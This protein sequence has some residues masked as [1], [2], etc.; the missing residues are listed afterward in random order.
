MEN[1]LDFAEVDNSLDFD[2]PML[3]AEAQEEA[4]VT[5]TLPE[6]PEE[7]VVEGPSEAE[8][9]KF[10]KIYDDLFF[11]GSYEETFP[12][13]KRY[14]C[15]LKSRT[16]DED[17][18]IARQL[19]GMQFQTMSAYQTMAAVLSLSY[20]LMDLNGTDYSGMDQKARYDKV[21]ALPS[22]VVEM[23]SR[24]MST[25]DVSIRNALGYGEENF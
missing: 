24:H 15:K 1:K 19:D 23:L 25:F 18:K 3:V 12:L 5:P 8:K 21:R 11:Q 17:V 4:E 9:A 14:S 22:Q 13:G 10:L 6:L 16:A 2:E 20:S 7:P